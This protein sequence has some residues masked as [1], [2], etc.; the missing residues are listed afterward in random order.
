M[1]GLRLPQLPIAKLQVQL[2][3]Y[4]VLLI[5]VLVLV[6]W[7]S[8]NVALVQ[9]H[10]SFVPMQYNTA[11]GFV[12][13]AGAVLSIFNHKTRVA[14]VL[15]SIVALI[16][17]LTLIEYGLD[18]E[19]GID[20]LF[21]E[22]YI[23]VKTSH[24]GRMAPNTALCFLLTGLTLFIYSAYQKRLRLL[25]IAVG[26]A[27]ILSLAF[28]AMLGYFFYVESL[29]GWGT[30]TRM[31]LHTSFSFIALGLALFGLVWIEWQ[32]QSI[33]LHNWLSYA[34]GM[35]LII[36]TVLI[37]QGV[38]ASEL[39]KQNKLMVR[40][41]DFI[42]A[43][44]QGR[45]NE[46]SAALHRMRNRQ[47]SGQD[48]N[49]WKIDAINYTQD[50]PFILILEN[51]GPQAG[52]H[53]IMA[54]NFSP[55]KTTER[56]LEAVKSTTS[57][58]QK[59][60]SGISH[61]VQIGNAGYASWVDIYEPDSSNTRLLIL[62]N[63]K[64]LIEDVLAKITTENRF[65]LRL[66]Y[67]Q[68]VIFDTFKT[69]KGSDLAQLEHLT[70]TY[71]IKFEGAPFQVKIRP[72]KQSVD[73]WVSPLPYLILILGI[74]VALLITW[75]LNLFQQLTEKRQLLELNLKLQSEIKEKQQ[76]QLALSESNQQL[77]S[78]NR[79]LEQFAF[80]ASHDL[81]EPLRKIQAFGKLLTE[82]YRDK[83][84][85]DGRYYVTTMQNAAE[86]MGQLIT[87]LLDFSRVSSHGDSLVACDLVR[88]MDR[89]MY[90]LSF[91]LEESK[92]E[93][94]IEELPTIQ[95]DF[96]QLTLLFQNL[97]SNAVKFHEPTRLLT[98]DIDA[99]QNDEHW[100]IRVKDNGIGF[101]QRYSEK[102]LQIF[103]RLHSKQKIPG[104]GIGLAICRRIME[105]HGGRI[106]AQGVV[107]KGSCFTL[108]FPRCITNEDAKSE[109]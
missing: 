60:A 101:E 39:V 54:P 106:D 32:R 25:L 70:H 78:S 33:P 66:F 19:L 40:E 63:Y 108:T 91:Q 36:L 43:N 24:P 92:A 48:I 99:T 5:G 81:K 17:G 77:L 109:N 47:K 107:N 50:F 79:D 82:E 90:N 94:R 26:P 86:R 13:S 72:S 21:M 9:I 42:L 52:Q 105:R 55:S 97:L 65:E 6:G 67:D 73:N 87:D 44:L 85:E 56:L 75:L 45:I 28:I 46:S 10:A 1:Q 37:W 89:A 35:S 16:G 15:S 31:A 18:V 59:H 100:L 95:G 7:Y 23:T 88:A 38:G 64:L 76:V 104:T 83:L 4:F 69:H 58:N 93:V 29:Y 61:P 27:A 12:L 41:A 84:T 8:N 22:H 71:S 98:I 20:Q 30:L 57:F 49:S 3:A 96:M 102:I 74:I 14:V 2:F 80:V 62:F 51:Q 68:S 34:I 103:Q 11:L 53:K